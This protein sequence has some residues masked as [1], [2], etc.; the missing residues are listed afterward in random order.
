MPRRLNAAL[1]SLTATSLAIAGCGSSDSYENKPRPPA[2]IVITASIQKDKVSV[3]P[4]SFGAGPVSL[5]IVNQTEAAQQVT[6]ESKG[7]TGGFTQET[8]PINPRDTA[9]LRA[10]V[11][12]GAAVV[13]VGGAGGI[14]AA[15]VQVGTRRGTAQN[16]LLQP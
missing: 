6:F 7:G 16:Q 12:T 14:Q 13:M 4:R 15:Q 1:V 8:G 5:I 10:D 9:T 2:P 11:P 3:S